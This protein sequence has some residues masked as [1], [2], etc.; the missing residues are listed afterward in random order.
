[1][2]GWHHTFITI[3]KVTT[4]FSSTLMYGSV[5]FLLLPSLHRRAELQ[6][7]LAEVTDHMEQQY[8]AHQYLERLRSENESLA[9]KEKDRQVRWMAYLVLTSNNTLSA[10]D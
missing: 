3:Y 9:L 5:L 10:L 7:V 1:M 6:R 8:S 4:L 2:P